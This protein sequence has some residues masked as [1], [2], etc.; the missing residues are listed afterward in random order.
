MIWLSQGYKGYKGYSKLC[1]KAESEKVR[2]WHTM[3]TVFEFFKGSIFYKY[4]VDIIILPNIRLA[5][6]TVFALENKK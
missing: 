1:K 5:Q 3:F 2:S 6:H 4:S